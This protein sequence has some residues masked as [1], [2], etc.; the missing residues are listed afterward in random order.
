MDSVRPNSTSGPSASPTQTTATAASEPALQKAP[1]GP[2]YFRWVICGLLLLGTTKNYMDRWVLSALKTTLQHDLGWSEIDY[3]HI[4]IAFQAAYAVGMLAVGGFIDRVGTR[5]GYAIVMIF[6]SFA[7]MAHAVGSSL[8]SFFVVRIALGFGESGVFPASI[9]AVAEWFP[10]KERA[11]AT[12]IFNAGT[13]VGVI[14]AGL[15]VPWI[16]LHFG[17]RWTFV[18]IGSLGFAWLALWLLLYRKPENHPRCS[19]TEL[20]YILGDAP[21]PVEKIKWLNLLPY[22]Q[23]WAYACGKF[24]T[25]PIWWFY[26]FWVPDFLERQHGV[27]LAQL[28]LPIVVI[29][30]ISDVGSVAGGWFSSSLIQKGVSVNAGRKIAMLVCA[31]GIVPIVF[32]SRVSGL[33]QA[34]LLIGLAAA[35]HQGFSANLY[36][37]TSDMFPKRAVASVVGIGGMAG[38]IGGML[39]AKIVGYVLQWTGSYMIP[40]FIAGSAYLLAIALIHVLAPRMEPAGIV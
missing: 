31:I 1:S 25:D 20:E 38:A 34:V 6:W 39:I 17:W 36:T 9:K 10:A 30:L 3:S 35:G 27:H 11:L 32:A 26:L 21:Q 40:F 5:L 28:G 19:K 4:V 2:G 8:S 18:I 14:L 7:S 24:L 22:R 29:Y 23:T 16:T 33:W 12:G 13:N 37:L 15:S